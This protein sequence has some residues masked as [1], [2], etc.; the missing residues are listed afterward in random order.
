MEGASAIATG[1]SHSLAIKSDD[2]LWIWGRNEGLEP[3]K[4]LSDVTAAAA[5]NRSTIALAKNAL[6]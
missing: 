4:V 1:S 6:W 3:K 5:G 2:S